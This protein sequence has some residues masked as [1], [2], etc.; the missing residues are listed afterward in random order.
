METSYKLTGNNTLVDFSADAHYIIISG[1]DGGFKI[2]DTLQNGI[3]YRTRLKG[4]KSDINIRNQAISPDKKYAGFSAL[5]KIFVVDVSQKEII[6]EYEYSKEERTL[7]ST[8]C[9]FHH[10]P[11]IAFPDGEYLWIHDIETGCSHCIALPHG[12]GMTDCIAIDP[13]DKIIAYKSSNGVNDIR[14]DREGNIVSTENNEELRDKVY[15]F[16]IETGKCLKILSVPYPHVWGAQ[17]YLSRTMKFVDMETVLIWR[18]G[19]GFSY[20]N[21]RTGAEM[22]TIDWHKKGFVC[23]EFEKAKIYA[24]DR[25]ILFNNATPDSGSIVFDDSGRIVKSYSLPI[26]EGLEYILYD[27]QED[28]VIYQQKIGEA[29]ATF[30]PETKQFAWIKREYDENYKRSEYLC[31]REL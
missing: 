8:F 26:P 7:S 9:F 5:N 13:T 11:R 4:S 15:I 30:H 28:R 3:Y 16:E 21:I 18:K 14:L 19:Y 1:Y 23:G 25:F 6:R 22:R 10:S 24:G 12:A 29:S 20:F 2:F 27:T 17:T 31:I